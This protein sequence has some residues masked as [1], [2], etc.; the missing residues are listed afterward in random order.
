MLTRVAP[1]PK[2]AAA[3]KA[4]RMVPNHSPTPAQRAAGRPL[5]RQSAAAPM[6]RNSELIAQDLGDPGPGMAAVG[7]CQTDKT[8]LLILPRDVPTDIVQHVYQHRI[9][10]PVRI[11]LML[12]HPGSWMLLD[13]RAHVHMFMVE[14]TMLSAVVA[15]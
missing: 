10:L 8:L 2:Q 13:G 3:P 1:A 6:Q 15:V 9:R 14:C 12:I 11:H 7:D 4:A 5:A